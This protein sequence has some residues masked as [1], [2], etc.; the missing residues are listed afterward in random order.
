M[1]GNQSSPNDD[2]GDCQSRIQRATQREVSH[3]QSIGYSL[4]CLPN[5]NTSAGRLG[6]ETCSLGQKCNVGAIYG[7]FLSSLILRAFNAT[8]SASNSILLYYA[9]FNARRS[10]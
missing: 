7:G 10:L 9:G 1:L 4:V 5:W 8:V 2:A 6:D 3:I